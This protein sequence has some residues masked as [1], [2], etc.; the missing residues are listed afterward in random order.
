[1]GHQTLL[2]SERNLEHIKSIAFCFVYDIS[3]AFS[4]IY[5]GHHWRHICNE[6]MNL[7]K[8]QSR[9]HFRKTKRP[10]IHASLVLC[11]LT[12]RH[13]KYLKIPLQPNGQ[14]G[15]Y[16]YSI[17]PE[18]VHHTRPTALSSG[19]KDLAHE[20]QPD[21]SGPSFDRDDEF[22]ALRGYPASSRSAIDR[23]TCRS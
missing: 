9:I 19:R 6:F 10:A 18:P 21:A 8:I 1:V 11:V 5:H 13:R 22:H 14:S 23:H 17:L 7:S 2:P 3:L 16:S 20:G 4:C 15:I 12:V